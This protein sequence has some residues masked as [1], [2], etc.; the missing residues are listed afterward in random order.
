MAHPHAVR[1]APAAIGTTPTT[2]GSLVINIRES[3]GQTKHCYVFKFVI[4]LPSE[5]ELNDTWK[6][7][8]EQKGVLAILRLILGAGVTPAQGSLKPTA[9]FKLN[10]VISP[11]PKERAPDWAPSRAIRTVFEL[12]DLRVYRLDLRVQIDRVLAEFAAE[13]GLLV[14]AERRH[15]IDLTVGVDPDGAGFELARDA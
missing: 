13:A 12:A 5:T 3:K 2:N 8:L 9:G 15:R 1:R 10:K 14:A 11:S 4:S 6:R 7:T